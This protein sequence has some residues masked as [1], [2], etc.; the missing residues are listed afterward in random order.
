MYADLQC[1]CILM[2]VTYVRRAIMQTS[3]QV[4][5]SLFEGHACR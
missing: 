4:L 5:M 3:M 1:S 2:I